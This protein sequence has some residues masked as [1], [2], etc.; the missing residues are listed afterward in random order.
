MQNSFTLQHFDVLISLA[1]VVLFIGYLSKF[2]FESTSLAPLGTV[3][4][5]AIKT[6]NT[7]WQLFILLP[8][9]YLLFSVGARL[10]TFLAAARFLP[11][12]GTSSWIFQPQF[13]M[14]DLYPFIT[15][16]ATHISNSIHQIL[17]FFNRFQFFQIIV[18]G[19]I[20]F[21]QPKATRIKRVFIAFSIIQAASFFIS[22]NLRLNSILLLLISTIPIYYF[23][24]YFY[25]LVYV[26][27]V[28]SLFREKRD[29]DQVVKNVNILFPKVLLLFY[30]SFLFQT[31]F[32]IIKVYFNAW[33]IPL[34]GSLIKGLIDSS[35]LILLPRLALWERSISQELKET[36]EWL[37]NSPTA[38]LAALKSIFSAAILYAIGS[39]TL[40]SFRLQTYSTGAYILDM[41]LRTL[42][43]ILLGYSAFFFLNYQLFTESQ[44]IETNA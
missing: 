19:I 11:N 35:I 9:L 30:I 21:K 23:S 42:I 33:Y 7:Y 5:F 27:L 12:D 44:P 41:I 43:L 24:A 4:K 10:Y 29:F 2:E 28:D 32:H 13:P 26:L 3:K 31:G 17:M 1:I 34:T 39:V 38:F 14:D 15:S 18:A 37:K 20:V 16:V 40:Q 25:A 22:I 8:L 36:R 6:I